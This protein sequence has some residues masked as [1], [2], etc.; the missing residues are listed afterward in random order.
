MIE[1]RAME[2]GKIKPIMGD[3]VVVTKIVE[4]DIE[5]RYEKD[6]R[7]YGRTRILRVLRAY[8]TDPTLAVI[9]GMRDVH[10]GEVHDDHGFR[11]ISTHCKH[12]MYLVRTSPMN[13]EVLVPPDGLVLANSANTTLMREHL[14]MGRLRAPAIRKKGDS[15]LL[16]CS[17]RITDG[18]P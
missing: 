13:R 18:G 15:V 11:Y 5:Y 8:T 16:D 12:R 4:R 9:V 3:V 14:V 7:G 2:N 17:E 10:T 6:D 1:V